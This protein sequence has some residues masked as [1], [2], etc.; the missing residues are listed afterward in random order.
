MAVC[1][2]ASQVDGEKLSI[3]PEDPGDNA[4][5]NHRGAAMED[6]N[7]LYDSNGA[8]VFT[9]DEWAKRTVPNKPG[10]FWECDVYVHG[11]FGGNC[12]LYIHTDGYV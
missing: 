1:V 10:L 6:Y 2:K 7:K 4:N 12:Y 9:P 11:K 5:G 8:P 3:S